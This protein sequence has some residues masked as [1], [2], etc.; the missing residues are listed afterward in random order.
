AVRRSHDPAG[1]GFFDVEHRLVRPD[2]SVRWTNIRSQTFFEGEGANRRPA[3]TVGAATDITDRKQAEADNARLEARL[4]QAQ[5]MES[6]GRLAGGVAHD[7]NNLLTV[8]N[9]YTDLLL[10]GLPASDP[11]RSRLTEIK[12]AGLRAAELTQQLLAFGREQ[13]AIPKV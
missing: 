2:G 1:D 5:K 4:S 11:A 9:G 3:R 6:I 7:F 10:E 12:N 8:I 13:I